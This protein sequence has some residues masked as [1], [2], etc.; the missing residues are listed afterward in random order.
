MGYGN[1]CSFLTKVNGQH[2]LLWEATDDILSSGTDLKM[3][4]NNVIYLCITAQISLSF[5][6]NQLRLHELKVR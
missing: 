2:G 4:L 5:L 6:W 1:I 3:L